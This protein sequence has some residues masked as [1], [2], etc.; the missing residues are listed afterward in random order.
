MERKQLRQ[1]VLDNFDWDKI[2]Y[3]IG[4]EYAKITPEVVFKL[5]NEV[6]GRYRPIATALLRTLG[7]RSW[8]IQKGVHEGGRSPNAPLHITVISGHGYHINC[9][10]N[11]DD[12]LYAYEVTDEAPSR[13]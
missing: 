13:D 2:N 9:K 10:K 8:H 12:T 5:L 7:T 6:S 4:S 11:D 1:N 3:N